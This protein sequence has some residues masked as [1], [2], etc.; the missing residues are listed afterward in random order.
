MALL[1]DA[2]AEDVQ[3]M[4]VGNVTNEPSKRVVSYENA[5]RFA[6]ERGLM[7][8]EANLDNPSSVNHAFVSLAAECIDFATIRVQKHTQSRS[9]GV[10]TKTNC[11]IM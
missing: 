9:S 11:T 4:I 10:I 8:L 3:L 2:T 7:Y 5:K 1:R 6:N